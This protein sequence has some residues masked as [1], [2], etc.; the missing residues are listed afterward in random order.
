[1]WRTIVAG[2]SRCS[3]TSCSGRESRGWSWNT[4]KNTNQSHTGFYSGRFWPM[5]IG[6]GAWNFTGTEQGQADF[7][8]SD[9][10]I[11]LFTDA[12]SRLRHLD[13]KTLKQSDVLSLACL[14]RKQTL[15]EM[16]NCLLLH[17]CICKRA[18]RDGAQN[19]LPF[20]WNKCFQLSQT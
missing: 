7:Q 17:V 10:F 8:T 3:P 14:H 12:W 9:M 1:M 11:N 4:W 15:S 18:I 16:R 2:Q 20:L 6:L 19:P 5:K 13:W